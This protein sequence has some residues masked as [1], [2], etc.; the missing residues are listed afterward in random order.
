MGRLMA[1][2]PNLLDD[3][4]LARLEQHRQ[5]MHAAAAVYNEALSRYSQAALDLASA[6]MAF[7]WS[8]SL[9]SDAVH[10]ELRQ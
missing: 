8:E 9:V 6:Q 4:L 10:G 1:G 7:A 5:Q 2:K 3:P